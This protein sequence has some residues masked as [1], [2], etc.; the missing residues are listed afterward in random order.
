MHI[1]NESL[2]PVVRG[3]SSPPSFKLRGG[4]W[5]NRA[6]QRNAS[7]GIATSRSC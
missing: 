7:S 5:K 2:I 3:K 1:Y 4:C 6:C